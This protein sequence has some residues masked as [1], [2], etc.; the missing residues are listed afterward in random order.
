MNKSVSHTFAD[1]S[2][3]AKSKWFSA[4]SLQERME[5]FTNSP[6]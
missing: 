6:I 3:E 1:E 4:L 5:V 2:L